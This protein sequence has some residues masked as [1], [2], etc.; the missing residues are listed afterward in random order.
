MPPKVKKRW[1]HRWLTFRVLRRAVLAILV[2]GAA[3]VGMFLLGSRSEQLREKERRH[4]FIARQ[5]RLKAEIAALLADADPRTDYVMAY[6]YT[7]N[8]LSQNDVATLEEPA[9]IQRA[10]QTIRTCAY[11]PESQLPRSP[12]QLQ[13]ASH[14][15]NLRIQASKHAEAAAAYHSAIWNPWTV[16]QDI[17]VEKD[18]PLGEMTKSK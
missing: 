9:A 17:G 14:S 8:V 3:S 4:A 10:Q 5:L 1:Y 15:A 6:H 16:T 12:Q 7:C 13:M 18:D 2:V 11:F